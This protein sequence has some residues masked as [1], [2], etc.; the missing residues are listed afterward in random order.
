M[1][2]NKT[3]ASLL[4]F[5]GLATLSSLAQAGIVFGVGASL[6]KQAY[7]EWAKQYKAE[8]G[9]DFVYFAQGSQKGIEAISAGK[10]DFGASDKPLTIEELEKNQ[11]VQFPS[12]IGGVVPVVNL[13]NVGDG[14]LQLDGAVLAGIYLGKIRRWNDPAITALNPRLA[15]PNETINV[16]HRAEKAGCTFT[17][18]DYLSKVSEEWKTT[19]GAALE[20]AWK[21]GEGVEGGENLAKQIGSTPNSIG[22]LDQALVQQ[23]HLTFV[24]MR[25]REGVFVSPY[26]GSFA[27]AAA[28][29]TWS[30]VNGYS[31]TLTDQPGPESW[32]LTTATYI[33]LARSPVETNGT[34]EAL[35][36]FDWAFRKGGAISQNLGF[37]SI[38]AE[39]MNNVRDSWKTQIKDRAG[40][41]LWK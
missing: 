14:Q 41:P 25:N 9:T 29:A 33:L 32:P 28:K 30:A 21:V 15:L 39:G 40:R 3:W 19:M 23:K 2:Q 31:Q 12:L 36:Y 20:V 35:K 5:V 22:Y 18:T 6:P 26:H 10:A 4:I 16:L 7:K 13:K 1:M 17:L 8:T 34:G 37:V 27:A 11:L 38:H 24:K